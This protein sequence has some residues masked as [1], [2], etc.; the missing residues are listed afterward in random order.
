MD[1]TDAAA[2]GSRLER[3]GRFLALDPDNVTLLRDYAAQ[4]WAAREL[5]A[6]VSALRR[7]HELGALDEGHAGLLVR[8]LA[9]SG[10]V[11]EAVASAAEALQVWPQSALLRFELARS[12]FLRNDLDQALEQLPGVEASDEIAAPVL[13]LRVRVLH[14]LGRLEDAVATAALLETEGGRA[15]VDAALLPVL[16]D[17]DRLD[18][19]CA[20]A[21]RLV[22]AQPQATP[23]EVCEPM[24]IAALDQGRPEQS[25]PWLERALS[26]RRDDGRIWLLS[27]LTHLQARD[28]PAAAQAIEQ[29]V[30]LMPGH[31]GS[32]LAQGWVALLRNDTV[33]ARSA[34][35]R[36]VQASPSFSEG[37]GSLA[38]LEALQG[39]AAEAD[40][41]IRTALLLDK[42]CASARLAQALRQGGTAADV[43]TLA[44]SVLARARVARAP[45][46]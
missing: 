10:Q 5:E 46:H 14:H 30:E 38:V 2:A 17:L 1:T 34:F 23:Y 6:C 32:H 35:E 24:A 31:A 19:A 21:Q 20:R 12:L 13:A 28:E 29:A 45:R 33:L 44:E 8:A 26:Q 27:A 3:L 41:H 43:R 42:Q 4:A 37:H 15:E 9:D 16:V 22:Q 18:E 11:E 7:L 39:R 36:G 40:A 25:R